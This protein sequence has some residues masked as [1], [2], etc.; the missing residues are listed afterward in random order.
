MVLHYVTSPDRVI[1]EMARVLRP[2]G[3]L[4]AVDFVSHDLKWM[5]Q[6][7]GVVWNGFPGETVR[8]WFSSAGLIDIAVEESESLAK[9]RDLPATLIAWGHVPDIA[10]DSR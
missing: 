9:D 2:G 6:E 10:D 1:R 5:E 8:D 7:L 3:T 4:V